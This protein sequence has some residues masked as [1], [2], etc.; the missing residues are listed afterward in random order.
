MGIL[1][2]ILNFFKKEEIEREKI[3]FEDIH[4]WIEKRD[5]QE[6]E[7]L[8][9]MLEFIRNEVWILMNSLNQNIETLKRVDIDGKKVEQ[10]AKFI[11][12]QNLDYYIANL[13]KLVRDLEKLVVEDPNESIKMIN[14]LFVEFDKKSNMNFQKATFLIGKELE[15][16]KK[17]IGDFFKNLKDNAKKN[18]DFLKIQKAIGFVKDNFLKID[19]LKKVINEIDEN[20]DKKNEEIDSL[21]GQVRDSLDLIEEIKKS[22]DYDNELKN[23]REIIDEEQNLKKMLGVLKNKVDFKALSNMFHSNK[24]EMGL[25]KDYENNFQEAFELNN[26]EN[27]I[28]LLK[29][30]KINSE[31]VSSEIGEVLDLKKKLIELKES[32]ESSESD[33]IGNTESEIE[34]LNHQISEFEYELSRKIRKLEKIY[35]EEL[36]F[37][38]EVKEK[39]DEIGVEVEDEN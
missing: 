36:E 3:D 10:R 39:L 26:G 29:D 23:R 18:K 22:E 37:K 31:V 20:I 32:F 19:K 14:S 8:N 24:K 27:L 25:I 35:E 5:V 7:E 34:K 2:S 12:K 4:K 6:K 33:K 11:V 30:A 15:E 13:K 16:T 38:E 9:E 21:R 17:I 1:D 28:E